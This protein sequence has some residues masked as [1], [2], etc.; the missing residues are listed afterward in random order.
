MSRY[1]PQAAAALLLALALSAVPA[2]A[3]SNPQQ[4]V[5]INPLGVV[6]GVYAG[7]FERAVAPA[8]SV[9]AS[10]SYWNNKDDDDDFSAEAT[11]FSV[12][13]KGRFYPGGIALRGFAIGGAM[14]YTSLSGSFTSSDGG[15][16]DKASAISMGVVLDYTWLMGEQD[17]FVVGTGLGA[18]RLFLR[19][20]ED[21]GVTA[22]YP[23][24]RV[25]VG[26]AW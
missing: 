21:T 11:Y 23:T 15:I 20:I 13:G 16:A 6:Y 24:I 4:Y 8:W 5:S 7:E 26:Y 22:A 14:G 12:D 1:L 18:K 2:Q 25:S 9:G 17:N 3:Q 19:G 10:S